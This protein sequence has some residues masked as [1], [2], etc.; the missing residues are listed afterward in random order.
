MIA[1]FSGIL[2]I[3]PQGRLFSSLRVLL[4]SQY[5]LI[6]IE[7]TEDRKAVSGILAA[8]HPRL[9][10]IDSSLLHCDDRSWVEEIRLANQD[11]AMVVLTH[12]P[13]DAP[14]DGC[15]N[16]PLEGLTSTALAGAID[17]YLQ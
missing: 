3:A 15:T 8:G 9:L 7:Q 1:D 6:D 17:I 2:L 14:M 11:R 5:P 13:E 4:R 10:M 16:L 12:Q